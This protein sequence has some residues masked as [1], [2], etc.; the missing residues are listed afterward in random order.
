MIRP[1]GPTLARRPCP[2]W[3]E[4]VEFPPFATQPEPARM[5]AERQNA[6]SLMIEDLSQRTDE[7]RRYL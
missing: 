5:D 3:T 4:R 2:R 7:L 6:I 1:I